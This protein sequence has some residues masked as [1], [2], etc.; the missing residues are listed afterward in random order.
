MG[1]E[2]GLYAKRGNRKEGGG[3]V[4]SGSTKMQKA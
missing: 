4:A 1:L 3:V 2:R